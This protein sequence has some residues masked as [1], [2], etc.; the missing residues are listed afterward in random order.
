MRRPR[1]GCSDPVG[2]GGSMGPRGCCWRARRSQERR[3]DDLVD[4]SS[5]GGAP[6]PPSETPRGRI[7][8]QRRELST[9]SSALRELVVSGAKRAAE[10]SH[11]E[12]AGELLRQAHAMVEESVAAETQALQLRLC[13][14]EGVGSVLGELRRRI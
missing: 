14:F 12:F 3:R 5:L 1:G 11:Q 8:E 7:D 2:C 6:D 13:A 10:E 4:G 9:E